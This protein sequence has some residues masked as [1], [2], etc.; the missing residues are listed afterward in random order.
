MRINFRAS[1]WAVAIVASIVAPAGA[2]Y[3]AMY[4]SAM[5]HGEPMA[6]EPQGYVDGGDCLDD[7][8]DRE[9]YDPSW[10]VRFG[11]LVLKRETPDDASLLTTT[12]GVDLINATDF[13][14]DYEPAVE[15]S[16]I[17]RLEDTLFA[18]VR[19]FGTDAWTSTVSGGPAGTATYPVVPPVTEAGAHL[20][21]STYSTQLWNGELNVRRMTEQGIAWLAGFR[22]VELDDNLLINSPP[23][24][25]GAVTE[26]RIVT[27]NRMYGFQ[28][29]ADG[30]LWNNGGALSID[31]V[32]KAAVFY[33]SLDHRSV[34]NQPSQPAT[35]ISGPLHVRDN[36]TSFLGEAF[37]SAVY[38]VTPN[39]SIR[40]GYGA[41]WVDGV[42]LASDQIEV[43]NFTTLSGIDAKG[44]C[45]YHG[46]MGQ[47]ELAW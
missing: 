1:A 45:F 17:G 26:Q 44:G 12:G 41:M 24:P 33:N 10:I 36:F 15:A 22:Y 9:A 35:A 43:T 29:G 8:M 7:C 14:W 13:K 32:V 6:A 23:I 42:A 11:A 31:G 38:H 18:E 21:S 27:N 25:L 5:R 16:I 46:A 40:V 3:P 2:Q 28:V 39:A 47:L 19:F 20:F 34:I 4:S 30:R 37:I